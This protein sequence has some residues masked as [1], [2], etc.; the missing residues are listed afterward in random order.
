MMSPATTALLANMNV[1][2]ASGRSANM[3]S[4]ANN[5]FMN[6]GHGNGHDKSHD[7]SPSFSNHHA[8]NVRGRKEGSQLHPKQKQ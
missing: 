3:N 1:S 6:D 5:S 2:I 8:D 4:N 7:S